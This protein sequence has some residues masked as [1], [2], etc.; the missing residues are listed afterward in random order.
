MNI[1]RTGSEA[2]WIEHRITSQVN[3]FH[4]TLNDLQ[5]SNFQVLAYVVVDSSIKMIGISILIPRMLNMGKINTL[6][7]R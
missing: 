1:R 6:A 5:N 2:V 7:L 4:V 3:S